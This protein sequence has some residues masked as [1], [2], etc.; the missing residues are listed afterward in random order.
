F[1][2]GPTQT[3]ATLSIRNNSQGGGGNDW[4]MDDVT[5][6]TC[7]PSMSYTPTLTPT[8]CEFN[9]I[10]INN[11]MRSYFGNYNYYKWQRSTDGGT[12]WVDIPGASGSATSELVNEQYQYFTSYT[13]PPENTTQAN[14]GDR[15]RQIVATAEV[16]LQGSTCQATDGV[17]I[18]SLNVLSD[19]IVLRTDLL[20]FSGK[21]Q[22]N[23]AQLSWTTSKEVEPFR[24]AIEKSIDGIH[25]ERI[26]TINGY[27]TQR[28]E[29]N[30]Y[31]FSDP[32]VLSGMVYYRIAM[33]DMEGKTKYSRTVRLGNKEEAFSVNVSTNPFDKH[34]SF[35]VTV[36]KDVKITARLLDATGKVVKEKAY[37]TH[38]GLN[39]FSIQDTDDLG[40]GIYI[41]QVHNQEESIRTKL[42][43]K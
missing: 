13:I 30:N 22:N 2:T 7:L 6:A 26:G 16:N 42:I 15:Y 3:S 19:C 29:I 27:N 21:I 1:I 41:L 36:D 5:V 33:I 20:S 31:T 8:V 14:N 37:T 40:S 17:S 35:S 11:T 32:A 24:F 10:T 4:A 38:A 9:P 34:L 12:N 43:K 25:F 18:I 23:H 28:A 39:K